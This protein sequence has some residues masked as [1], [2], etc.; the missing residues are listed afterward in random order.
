MPAIVSTDAP[1]SRGGR[2][3]PCYGRRARSGDQ[4]I[5][6]KSREL[7]QAHALSLI[8]L[9]ACSPKSRSHRELKVTFLRE[10]TE[11]VIGPMCQHARVHFTR[12]FTEK[13]EPGWDRPRCR[14]KISQF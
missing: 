11:L 6:N 4:K 12:R 10:R 1:L 8:G 3:Q 2:E 9:R 7:V 13:I 5:Q 14:V